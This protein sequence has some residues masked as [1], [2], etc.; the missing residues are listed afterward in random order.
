MEQR[1]F[2]KRHKW[3]IFHFTWILAIILIIA[4]FFAGVFT[5]TQ[6]AK[7]QVNG[8]GPV[9]VP[10]SAVDQAAKGLDEHQNSRD[11]FPAKVTR[12]EFQAGRAQQERLAASDQLP[13]VLPDAAPVQRGCT[14]TFVVNYSSRQGIAPRLLIVHYTVSPNRVG[15]SDDYSVY[16]EFNTPSFQAS[17]NYIIDNE[18]HCLY[19][20]READ[21]AWT[22]A[23][24]NPVGVSIEII[25]SGSE[26][27]LAGTAGLKKIAMVLSDAGFRWKIPIRLGAVSGC[28]VTRSGIVDH[29]ML[30]QCGGGHHDIHPYKVSKVIAAVQQFR[31]SQADLTRAQLKT[32]YR[33]KILAER[34]AGASWTTIKASDI[35]KRYVSLGG[36]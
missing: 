10:K 20:V 26:P 32:A 23:G 18:G 21:K 3:H 15:W 4:A 5:G 36:K 6:Y 1:S 8:V 17:S 16:H 12:S 7:F 28:T 33:K 14:S 31:S 35:W 2:I 29:Y 13:L 19:I 11:E 30:G 25:N 27:T 34:K 24:F 22:Q 9:S